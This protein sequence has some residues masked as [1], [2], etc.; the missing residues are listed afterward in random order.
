M[1]PTQAVITAEDMGQGYSPS[2]RGDNLDLSLAQDSVCSL[3]APETLSEGH[4]ALFLFV[5]K[6]PQNVRLT[7][8]IGDWF[9]FTEN[10]NE[11]V[12][13]YAQS[14]IYASECGLQRGSKPP[15]FSNQ[16]C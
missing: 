15:E 6:A 16:I 4:D 10:L 1:G 3:P 5:V 8:E 9:L 14:R 12:D 2:T 7:E 11:H 13:E